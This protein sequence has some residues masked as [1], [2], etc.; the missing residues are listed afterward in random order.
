MRLIS[1]K[2]GTEGPVSASAVRRALE[3]GDAD[4]LSRLVPETTLAYLQ[5]TF[6]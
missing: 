5:E 2:E 6:A 4:A 3:A 1:R